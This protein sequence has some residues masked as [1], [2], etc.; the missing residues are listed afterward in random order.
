MGGAALIVDESLP[1]ETA[2]GMDCTPRFGPREPVRCLHWIIT[3]ADQNRCRNRRMAI[4]DAR[5]ITDRRAV[6]TQSQI[7]ESECRN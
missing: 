3:H 5:D 4:P 6:S 1:D 7:D 2:S